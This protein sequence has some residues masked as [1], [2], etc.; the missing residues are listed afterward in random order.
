MTRKPVRATFATTIL[1]Q[2]G[3]WL[4]Q[5][6]AL[7]KKHD[8]ADAIH[9]TRVQ[10]RRMR[11]AL[12]AFQDLI[13][14]AEWQEFYDSVRRITRALGEIR[15]TEVMC[16]LLD[17]LTST[18]DLGEQLAREFLEE[19]LQ[20]RMRKLR[21][22]LDGKLSGIDLRLLRSRIHRLIQQIAPDAD[23]SELERARRVLREY[24]E[25]ILAFKVRR[26]FAR[27]SDRRLH[28]I[29]IAA[30]KL[31]YF[32]EV[33]DPCWPGG[34]ERPIAITRALQDAGGIHQD[35]T[36]LRQFLQTEIKRLSARQRPHMA[37]QASRLLASAAI[38]K[39]ELRASVLPALQELQTCL[40]GLFEPAE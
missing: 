28:R 27:A 22:R 23:E 31:R 34:L 29:R 12:E 38:R 24:A 9:D 3:T 7:L 15:E 10:S 20:K 2:R 32:M 14:A 8:G 39:S 5:Q 19:M 4:I 26:Q 17:G 40:H 6:L 18:D 36:V 35:W 11:A 33:F 25:P 16:S 30:K 1:W 21:S 37:A 13:P